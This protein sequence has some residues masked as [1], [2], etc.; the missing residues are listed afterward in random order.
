MSTARVPASRIAGT[1]SGKG[2]GRPLWRRVF[3]WPS[4]R[5]RLVGRRAMARLRC[6]PGRVWKASS[7]WTPG[8]VRH[9]SPA[10]PGSLPHCSPCSAS[11]LLAVPSQLGL[12]SGAANGHCWRFSHFC[13]GCSGC[14]SPLDR[15]L[16]H[17]RQ[18][19]GSWR[20]AAR[21]SCGRKLDFGHSDGPGSEPHLLRRDLPAW[22]YPDT[23]RA[24]RLLPV[25]PVKHV[26]PLRTE[27]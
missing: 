27:P 4:N 20:G 17:F 25:G 24:A 13:G 2:T 12:S 16:I 18:D 15:S 23:S 5:S 22:L 1:G 10:R 26:R 7:C 21:S 11:A 19:G 6:V 8:P 14:T 3:R 9:S